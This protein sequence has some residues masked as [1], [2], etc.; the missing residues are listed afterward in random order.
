MKSTL[1]SWSYR[2]SVLGLRMVTAQTTAHW[3][4]HLLLLHHWTLLQ[5]TWQ[6]QLIE[7]TNCQKPPVH[8]EVF[9][10]LSS[11]C[12]KNRDS[13][14]Y[15]WTIAQLQRRASTE[16]QSQDCPPIRSTKFE[17]RMRTECLQCY[18]FMM[19]YLVG[20]RDITFSS[21]SNTVNVREWEF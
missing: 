9:V 11:L 21:V 14:S 20:S 4:H 6:L 15:V 7:S 8:K 18:W 5:V 17:S 10:V 19:Q 13:E 12:S 16:P 2:K 3:S 1:H